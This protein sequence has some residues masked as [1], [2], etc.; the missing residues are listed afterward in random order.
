MRE[1]RALL[2]KEPKKAL[3]F[4]ELKHEQRVPYVRAIGDAN[5]RTVS[6]LIHKPSIKEPERFQ[7]E[8][9]R[10]YLRQS[11]ASGTGFV[12]VPYHHKGRR[13]AMALWNTF[14]NR[15]AMSYDD[16][17]I[18]SATYGN[19]RRCRC[20]GELARGAARGW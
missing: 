14:S 2:K 12:V 15:S 10:L 5:L 1:V 6:V 7:S 9:F 8:S 19:R 13:K 20:S 18:I 17:E 4:R 16:L 11:P 3:H